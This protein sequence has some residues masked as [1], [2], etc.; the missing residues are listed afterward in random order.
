VAERGNVYSVSPAET[1]D[2]LCPLSGTGHTLCASPVNV[3][4]PNLVTGAD[5][6]GTQATVSNCN[7]ADFPNRPGAA[8]NSVPALTGNNFNYAADSPLFTSTT[9]NFSAVMAYFHLDKHVSFFKTLDPT[10]PGG[11][12]F[13]VNGSLPA[14]VNV[15]SGGQSFEN[16]FYDG[17]IDAVKDA[18]G[19]A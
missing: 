9:D 2:S 12:L 16:A 7:G 13:A 11:T 17:I 19:D 1:S 6:R 4:I 3:T 18:I 5:L 8:C 15:R 10:L 14:F